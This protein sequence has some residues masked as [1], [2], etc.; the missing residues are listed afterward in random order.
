[1]PGASPIIIHCA[2]RLPTPNTDWVRVVWSEHAVQE[3][4]AWLNPSQSRLAT[5]AGNSDP[6]RVRDRDSVG[7]RRTTVSTRVAR[8]FSA[9]GVSVTSSSVGA[10]AWAE[11]CTSDLRVHTSI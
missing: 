4:T 10:T 3:F 5:E 9:S 1:M 6:A 2:C 8:E 7:T 11:G